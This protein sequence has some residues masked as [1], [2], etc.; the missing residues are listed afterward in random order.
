MRIIK[1]LE[2]VESVFTQHH[3]SERHRSH[4]QH[5]K[6]TML[7]ATARPLRSRAAGREG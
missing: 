2:D 1:M 6:A 4:C 3:A 7:L 5:G